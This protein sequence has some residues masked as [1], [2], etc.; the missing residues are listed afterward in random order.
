M[1]RLKRVVTNSLRNLNV[2]KYLV[3]AIGEIILIVAG[4]LIAVSISN[5]NDDR[6]KEKR[7]ALILENVSKDLD[8]DLNTL[9]RL[10]SAYEKSDSLISDITE[11]KYTSSYFEG[12][13]EGNYDD[14]DACFANHIYFPTFSPKADGYNQLKSFDLGS[15]KVKEDL[16]HDLLYF[17]NSKLKE[18]PLIESLL[19]EVALENLKSLEEFDWYANYMIGKYNPESISYFQNDPSYRNKLITFRVI[20]MENHYALLKIYRSQ[21]KELL[22]RFNKK[23]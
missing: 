6:K 18:M 19:A 5:Y 11:G 2:K 22:K 23:Q 15:I 10:I 9:D 12:I 14:C 3:Y 13:N 17:Y 16:T 4:V 7:L 1:G 20:A 21:A 8:T